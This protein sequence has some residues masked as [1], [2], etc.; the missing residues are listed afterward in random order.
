MELANGIKL[1]LPISSKTR[2]DLKKH[3]VIGVFDHWLALKATQSIH[4]ILKIRFKK[5]S[6]LESYS[7]NDEKSPALAEEKVIAL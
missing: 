6:L 2:P 3:I 7:W 5:T 4:C 1:F